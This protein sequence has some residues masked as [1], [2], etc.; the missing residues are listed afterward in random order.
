[1]RV[2]QRQLLTPQLLAWP[3]EHGSRDVDLADVVEP[4]GLPRELRAGAVGSELHGD[5]ERV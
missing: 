2:Q 3:G 5:R 1:M 4:R